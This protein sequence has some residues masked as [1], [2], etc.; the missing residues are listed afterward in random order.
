MKSRLNLTSDSYFS[1]SD[2]AKRL[3]VDNSTIRRWA[4]LGEI[5]CFR[6]LGGHRRFTEDAIRELVAKLEFRAMGVAPSTQRSLGQSR[7]ANLQFRKT[8]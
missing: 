3:G 1:T 2:L 8:N 7:T 4:D 6:T 5:P